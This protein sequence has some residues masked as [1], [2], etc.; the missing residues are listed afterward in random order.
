MSKERL[1][2]QGKLYQLEEERKALSARVRAGLYVL[3][4]VFSDVDLVLD[5]SRFIDL[6]IEMVMAVIEDLKSLQEKYR[7]ITNH[8]NKLK[9]DL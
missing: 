5:S 6:D 7:E 3:R 2:R 4:S 1:I 8:I 9:E